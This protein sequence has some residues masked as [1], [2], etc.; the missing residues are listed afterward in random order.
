MRFFDREK[1]KALLERTREVAFNVHSQMTV[2]TGRR[3]IGKTKLIL[4]SYAD[5]PCLYLFVSRSNEAQ[6]CEGFA[7][8]A[9]QTLGMFIPTGIKTFAALFELLMQFGKHQSFTLVIDE[10]QDFTY[11]NTAVF[12][13]MQDIWDRYKDSTHVNLVISGSVYTL[14]TRLFQDAKEPLF[15]RADH[16]LNLRPFRTKVIQDILQE[17][18]PG[19]KPDDLLALYTYTGGIPKYIEILMDNGCFTFRKMVDFMTSPDSYFLNE[20]RALLI[21][22]FGRDYGSYFSVLSAI[23]QGHTLPR[24]IASDMGNSE[25]GGQ[26]KRLEEDYRLIAKNRPAFAKPRSQTIRYEISDIFLRTW[27][28]YFYRYRF[29]IEAEQYGQLADILIKDYQTYSGR[30]LEQWFREKLRE[31]G[32][33]QNVSGWWNRTKGENPAELDI[34]A[35]EADGRKMLLAE[36]KR[37]RRHFDKAAFDAKINLFKDTVSP[38]AEIEKKFFSLE[39]M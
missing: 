33:Y 4:T 39:D 6:L 27:F 32:R 5:K 18:N 9:S 38:K 37:Q 11:I 15:G 1:E 21:S 23:A 22:E 12:S 7:Q 26:L 30:I 24:E 36:V 34:V 13:Q 28:R 31:T 10:F 29:L 25:I 2:V 17:H 20:G 19:F 35:L 14:M 3:R 16:I 8:L